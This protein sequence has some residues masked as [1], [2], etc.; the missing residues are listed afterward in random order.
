M[1]SGG[2]KKSFYE[3]SFFIGTLANALN[4]KI[5]RLALCRVIL[6]LAILAF[7]YVNSR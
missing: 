1:F 3:L 4:L 6:I 2:E 5:N 7:L